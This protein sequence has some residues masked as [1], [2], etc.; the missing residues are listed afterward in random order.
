MGDQQPIAE[1]EDYNLQSAE[2]AAILKKLNDLI[3]HPVSRH[4]WA[5]AQLCDI[6]KLAEMLSWDEEQASI[7]SG[8]FK[9]EIGLCKLILQALLN[10]S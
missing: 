9:R 3:G 5:A 2:R 6:E 10:Y 7:F 8:T 4:F 1:N